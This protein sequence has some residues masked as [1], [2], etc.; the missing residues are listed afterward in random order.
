M[1][2]TRR[3]TIESARDDNVHRAQDL[4][5]SLREV[6][7]QIMGLKQRRNALLRELERVENEL[8]KTRPGTVKPI[9]NAKPATLP[10]E[11]P[12]CGKHIGR[13]VHI[14]AKHCSG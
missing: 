10:G 5:T 7:S 1:S 12:K 13:G 9:V 2:E 4:R 11:C 8:R 3:R 6:E 14:H